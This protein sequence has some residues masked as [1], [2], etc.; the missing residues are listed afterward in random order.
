MFVDSKIV[1]IKNHNL[2]ILKVRK[3]KDEKEIII[4]VNC[5]NGI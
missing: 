3:I 5:S 2:K 4:V 1:M